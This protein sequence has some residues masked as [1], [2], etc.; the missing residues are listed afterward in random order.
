MAWILTPFAILM[1]PVLVFGA[2]MARAALASRRRR[3]LAR[4]VAEL[5]RELRL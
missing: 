4:R 1:A 3:K 5:K 2:N